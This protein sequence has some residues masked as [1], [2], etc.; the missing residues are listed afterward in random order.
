MIVEIVALSVAFLGGYKFG[1]SAKKELLEAMAE[2]KASAEAALFNL[3][4]KVA[5]D[6]KSVVSTVVADVKSAI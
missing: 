3:Q 2:G 1:A 5:K 6:A 4:D